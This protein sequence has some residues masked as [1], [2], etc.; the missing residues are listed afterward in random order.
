MRENCLVAI[1]TKTGDGTAGL[2]DDAFAATRKEWR[3]RRHHVLGQAR[4]IA[5]FWLGERPGADRAHIE[6]HYRGLKPCLH[7]SDAHRAAEPAALTAIA[8]AG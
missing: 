5:L 8:C 2:Q 7:G 3:V 1:A 4:A 6:R